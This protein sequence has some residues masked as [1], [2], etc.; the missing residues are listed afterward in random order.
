[1]HLT[2]LAILLVL[3]WTLFQEKQG[4]RADSEEFASMNDGGNGAGNP[5]NETPNE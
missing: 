3:G 2:I 4:K 5:D 1:M